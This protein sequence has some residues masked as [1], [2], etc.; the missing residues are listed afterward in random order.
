MHIWRNGT[1]DKERFYVFS[2]HKSYYKSIDKEI[3]VWLTENWEKWEE[4]KQDWF[5]AR[6]VKRVPSYLL[7]DVVL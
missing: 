5:T 3:K 7:P 6:T 4:E 2:K 1:S